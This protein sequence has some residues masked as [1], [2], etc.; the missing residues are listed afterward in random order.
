MIVGVLG[1]YYTR[2]LE[3][4][5]LFLSLPA[6]LLYM[7]GIFL[8]ASA[9]FYGHHAAGGYLVTNAGRLSRDTPPHLF[10]RGIFQRK[11]FLLLDI[12]WIVLRY[13][14]WSGSR[15]SL[16]TLPQHPVDRNRRRPWRGIQDHKLHA[17]G[18]HAGTPA[19]PLASRQVVT[20]AATTRS[21]SSPRARFCKASRPLRPQR[22]AR[23]ALDV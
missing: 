15:A 7:I 1:E 4:S 8:L 11:K 16:P 9:R 14:L 12:A 10:C 21:R 3:S 17:S 20:T 6:V 2:P 13:P 23:Q 5:L 18:S 19:D 22:A